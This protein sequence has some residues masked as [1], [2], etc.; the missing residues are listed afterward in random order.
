[1]AL[2]LEVFSNDKTKELKEGKRTFLSNWN[3]QC[4][5]AGAARA[6]FKCV[7]AVQ[8]TV[9]WFNCYNHS[10]VIFH[11]AAIIADILQCLL[12]K[13]NNGKKLKNYDSR[14]CADR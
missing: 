6:T 12:L 10:L 1:M 2:K 8:S 7:A 5:N 14:F 4:Y 3:S 9:P 11:D 13:L